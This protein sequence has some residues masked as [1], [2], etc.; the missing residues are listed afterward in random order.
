MRHLSVNTLSLVLI[1][2]LL[3]QLV[4]EGQD[5]HAPLVDGN[6]IRPS[7]SV[8]AQPVWGHAEGLRIGLWPLPGPR[9]LLRVYAPYLGHHDDRMI[10]YIA[11]EPVLKGGLW[12]SFSELEESALDGVQGMRFWSSNS[13]DDATPRDPRQP[14]RGVV[15][16]NGESETLSVYIFVEPFASGARI[17]LRL[18]FQ[19]DRPY[20]VGLSTFTQSG[21]APISTCI[22]TA[23]MGNFARLRTL[24]LSGGTRSALDM[25]P[26]FSGEGFADHICF[27]LDDLIRTPS[28]DAL[29]ISTPDEE[30]PAAAEYAKGTFIGWRYYGDVATQYWRK[31]DPPPELRGCVNART[32]YWASDSKIPGGISF[33]NL[34]LIEPFVEGNQSWF[35]V[36]QGLYEHVLDLEKLRNGTGTP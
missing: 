3:T 7:E 16:Q 26:D 23:T 11:V 4:A 33:E 31:E 28:G 5:L 15:S 25:W 34:E 32:T 36:A 1:L 18:D 30:N 9:G 35:G 6:W 20:E 14:A 22:L 24:H 21:S 19:S 17:V 13:P 8:P 2:M 29:F 12:R 27:L 10:N